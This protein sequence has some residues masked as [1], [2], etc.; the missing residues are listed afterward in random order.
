MRGLNNS[1]T[2]ERL[3]RIPEMFSWLNSSKVM[4]TDTSLGAETADNMSSSEAIP[5]PIA[6]VI[7]KRDTAMA[8]LHQQSRM[9]RTQNE[10]FQYKST[11][12]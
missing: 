6:S 12:E 11:H 5:V 10:H 1:P 4:S 2:L 7:V 9:G 8:Y 3:E